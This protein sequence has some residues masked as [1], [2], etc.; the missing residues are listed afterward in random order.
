MGKRVEGSESVETI[1]LDGAATRWV[2]L[3]R[4]RSPEC[5]AKVQVR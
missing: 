4:L 2:V 1:Q 3:W 5:G